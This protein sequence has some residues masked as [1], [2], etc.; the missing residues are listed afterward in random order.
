M[1]NLVED[2][3]Q[4]PKEQLEALGTIKVTL[5]SG[6]LEMPRI[7]APMEYDIKSMSVS[8]KSKK[9]MIGMTVA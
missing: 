2:E 8:E 1:Q 9:G 3:A 7:A 5:S 4:L 6:R